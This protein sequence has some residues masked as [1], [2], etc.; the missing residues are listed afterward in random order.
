MKKKGNNVK[1]GHKSIQMPVPVVLNR[2]M[3]VADEGIC[4]F[5]EFEKKFLSGVIDDSLALLVTARAAAETRMDL[6]IMVY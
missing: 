2:C 5:P 3:T 6:G 4:L 1:K